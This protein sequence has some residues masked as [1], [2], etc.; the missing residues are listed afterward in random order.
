MIFEHSVEGSVTQRCREIKWEKVMLRKYC[1]TRI[2]SLRSISLLGS[3]TR[4][5]AVNDKCDGSHSRVGASNDPKTLSYFGVKQCES[6]VWDC[7]CRSRSIMFPHCR[8][9]TFLWGK[10]S[11]PYLLNMLASLNLHSGSSSID[12]LFRKSIPKVY[13]PYQFGSHCNKDW[14][15]LVVIICQNML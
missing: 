2:T 6:V 11:F 4:N 15:F 9:T 7:G 14:V 1:F 13:N 5:T 12:F 10:S 3:A 8:L